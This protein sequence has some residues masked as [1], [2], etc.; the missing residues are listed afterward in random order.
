MPAAALVPVAAAFVA[1]AIVPTVA[2][3]EEPDD[4]AAEVA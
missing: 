3:T 1:F 4:V 2:M